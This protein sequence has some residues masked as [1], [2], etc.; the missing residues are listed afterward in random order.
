[1]HLKNKSKRGM[2]NIR[3]SAK[4]VRWLVKEFWKKIRKI[5]L[6]NWLNCIVSIIYVWMGIGWDF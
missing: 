3:V 4:V 1:M 6:I 2:K 5:T